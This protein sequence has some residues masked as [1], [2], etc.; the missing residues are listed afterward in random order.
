MAASVESTEIGSPSQDRM[1]FKIDTVTGRTWYYLS[2]KVKGK[3]VEEWVEIE[4]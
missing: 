1:L 2:T 4:Q 3:F